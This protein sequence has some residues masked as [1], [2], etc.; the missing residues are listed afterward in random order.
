MWQI[1]NLAEVGKMTFKR[2]YQEKLIHVILSRCTWG[3]WQKKKIEWKHYH[4]FYQHK[5]S[6]VCF[7]VCFAGLLPS[8]SL[9]LPI[10]VRRLK[11]YKR[12]LGHIGVSK[13]SWSRWDV[14]LWR[15]CLTRVF[16]AFKQRLTR[17]AYSIAMVRRPSVI[18]IHTFKLNPSHAANIDKCHCCWIYV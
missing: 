8:I 17:W 16:P 15:S 3:V 12:L 5:I 13:Q 9:V 2:I 14:L 11:T 10:F 1:W 4:N 18:V 6:D 7:T